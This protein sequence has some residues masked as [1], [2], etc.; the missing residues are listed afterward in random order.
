[1]GQPETAVTRERQAN[2]LRMSLRFHPE[3]YETSSANKLV[4]EER[5]ERMGTINCAPT[6]RIYRY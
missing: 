5:K 2:C 1:M 6:K 3:A 4:F